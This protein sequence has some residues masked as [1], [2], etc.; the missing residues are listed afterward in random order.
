M[1]SEGAPGWP[2]ALRAIQ[3]PRPLSLNRGVTF[4]DP[5]GLI[6]EFDDDGARE[7]YSQLRTAASNAARSK[8]RNRAAAGR[9]LLRQLDA[10]ESAPDVVT[11]MTNDRK[12]DGYGDLEGTGKH[13]ININP[14]IN[15]D[16]SPQIR[17]AHELG[18]AYSDFGLNPG[19][20]SQQTALDTENRARSF[21]WGCSPRL[22][23]DVTFLRQT[24]N[25]PCS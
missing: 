3:D 10:L 4:T 5:F 2:G 21:W 12:K 16:H 25:P 9:A 23:H 11:I 13:F 22:V 17:L 7:L 1:S 18:H 6:V 15:S 8:D 19:V 24:L 20:S 14:T